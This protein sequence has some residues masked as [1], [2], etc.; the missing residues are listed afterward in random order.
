MDE[1]RTELAVRMALH[2]PGQL[3][4]PE[5]N[6]RKR[7]ED[8]AHAQLF[9]APAGKAR[10]ALVTA[11]HKVKGAAFELGGGDCLPAIPGEVLGHAEDT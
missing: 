1:V 7:C 2:L 3:T 4:W 9:D 5:P 8:C 10:C 11:H 6:L